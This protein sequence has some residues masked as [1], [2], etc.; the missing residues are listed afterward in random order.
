M[1]ADANNFLNLFKNICQ[2]STFYFTSKC[3]N[4]VESVWNDPINPLWTDHIPPLFQFFSQI[5]LK[6]IDAIRMPGYFVFKAL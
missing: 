6:K 5:K 1:L 2:K 3:K 4:L